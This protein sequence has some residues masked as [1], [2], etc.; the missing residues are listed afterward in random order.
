MITSNQITPGIVLSLN[1]KIYRVESSVKVTVTKGSPFMKTKLKDLMTEEVVEKNFKL[2][3][4]V[5]EVSLNERRLEFLYP[6]GKGY[7]FLD[8]DSLDQVLVAGPVVGDKVHFLKEGVGVSALFY[9]YSIYSIEL[10][11]FL[12]LMVLKAPSI[13]NKAYG[14]GHQKNHFG[15]G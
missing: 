14:G 1:K 7:L 9:G 13:K 4:K 12:E 15:D 6:E 3:E 2:G 11:Q 8:T 10:P 5:D